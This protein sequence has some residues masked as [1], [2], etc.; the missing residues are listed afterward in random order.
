MIG[1]GFEGRGVELFEQAADGIAISA[2]AA[3]FDHDVTF[4]IKL[5]QHGM[6]EALRLEIGPELQPI[7]RQRVVIAGLV[8][9]GEGV[10]ILT[11]VLLDD[12]AE[13]VGHHVFVGFGDGV[14]PRFFQLL[15]LGL[16]AAHFFIALGDVSGIGGFDFFQRELLGGV[17]GGADLC[18]CP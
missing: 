15:Q 3:L 7:R 10:E 14:F 17:V 1:M 12:L 4:F 9:I 8:V 2:Q 6:K 18:P 16:V 11:A 13:L 5:A